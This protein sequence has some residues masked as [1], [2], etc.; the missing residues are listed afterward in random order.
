MWGQP[1]FDKLRA[2]S[3]LSRRA[4]RGAQL[5]TL[6][7]FFAAFPSTTAVHFAPSGDIS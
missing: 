1:P 4:K 6:T 7:Y 2:G 3:R 5:K